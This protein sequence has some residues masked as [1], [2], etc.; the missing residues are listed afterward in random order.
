M[1]DHFT[2]YLIP[3][4]YHV[5]IPGILEVEIPG[6]LMINRA[7]IFTPKIPAIFRL[8]TRF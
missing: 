3:G 8:N 5:K 4:I 1:S 2:G 6:I 7:G